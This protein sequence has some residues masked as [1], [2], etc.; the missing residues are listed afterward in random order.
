MAKVYK[1]KDRSVSFYMRIP[2]SSNPFHSMSKFLMQIVKINQPLG[3]KPRLFFL[4]I[5]EISIKSSSDGS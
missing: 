3:L 2:K 5:L 4:S 1:W